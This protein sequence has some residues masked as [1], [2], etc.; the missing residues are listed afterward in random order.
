M[1]SLNV[2]LIGHS[3]SLALKSLLQSKYLNKLYGNFEAENVINLKFN[4]FR[5]LAKK[6][7]ALK[8]DLV[9]VDD[10]K[11]VFQGIADVLRLNYINCFSLCS[12]SAK[13][14]LSKS[15]AKSILNKYEI[16]TPKT[17]L[18]PSEFPLFVKSDNY[19]QIV[20]SFEEVLKTKNFIAQNYPQTIN[21]IYLEE[22]VKGEICTLNSFYDGKN[23]ITY[24][25]SN[26]KQE[27]IN[28]YN[29]KLKKLFI[30]EYVNFIGYINANMIYNTSQM[31][32]LGF[33]LKFPQ[34]NND[35]LYFIFSAIYQKL[36]EFHIS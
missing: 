17:L 9:L 10:E 26:I 29:N 22:F 13:L 15:Y 2:M 33:N 34:I 12:D 1:Q 28:D 27:L 6:C 5:E 32:C 31:Y 25:N 19:S 16:Y 30:A 14:V 24:T 35:I 18:Y 21:T 23:I 36:N 11:L 8:I 20:N 4:T 3:Q 7:R